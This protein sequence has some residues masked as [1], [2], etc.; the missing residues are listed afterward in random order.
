M[1][2]NIVRIITVNYLNYLSCPWKKINDEV[3]ALSGSH[4]VTLIERF[5][6]HLMIF[7]NSLRDSIAVVIQDR[8]LGFGIFTKTNH[9]IQ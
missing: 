3:V 5:L 2:K 6:K 7:L 1:H 4:S 8:H 9:E